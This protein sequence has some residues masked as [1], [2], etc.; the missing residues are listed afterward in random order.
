MTNH[1]RLYMRPFTTRNQAIKTLEKLDQASF[2][3]WCEVSS[4]VFAQ[5][6]Q[7][8]GLHLSHD[9]MHYQLYMPLTCGLHTLY[10]CAIV[11]RNTK[12]V[13]LSPDSFPCKRLGSTF[14]CQVIFVIVLNAEYRH[15]VA[16]L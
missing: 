5:A 11:V 15:V 16:E 7:I 4:L 1:V 12:K 3:G 9:C 10:A 6:N 14:L 8:A 13:Q 2:K